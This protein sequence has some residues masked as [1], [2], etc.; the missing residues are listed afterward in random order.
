M[1]RTPFKASSLEEAFRHHLPGDVSGPECVEWPRGIGSTGYG[2]LCFQYRDYNAHRVS[3]MIHR[4]DIP[5]S[6]MVLHD[7]E[8]CNNRRCV[9]PDH[10]RLGTPA[11]NQ[12]DRRV[13]GTDIRGERVAGAKLEADDVI[14]IR[15]LRKSGV[16]EMEL[17]ERYGV[18]RTSINLIINRKTWAHLPEEA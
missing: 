5:D 8:I 17:A 16:T 7:P 1:T 18:H 3:Y 13:A 11:E 10:L 4:G 9:N 15:K 6:M 12:H 14:E 2:K